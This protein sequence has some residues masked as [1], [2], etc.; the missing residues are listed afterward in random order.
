MQDNLIL[1]QIKEIFL[2]YYAQQVMLR[3]LVK[4]VKRTK[5]FNIFCFN[6]NAKIMVE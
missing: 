3:F 1:L 4:I 5:S 6:N 2:K